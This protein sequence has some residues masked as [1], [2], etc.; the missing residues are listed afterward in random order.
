MIVCSRDGVKLPFLT[1]THSE[2]GEFG[3]PKWK[4]LHNAIADLDS[5]VSHFIKFSSKRERFYRLLSAGQNWKDLPKNL[6]KEALGNSY[7]AG[8]GKTGFY[9]RLSWNKPSP[10]L[11][12]H[13]AMPATDLAHPQELRPLSVEE[14]KKIQEFPDDWKI[15]GNILDQYKQIGNAVPLSLGYAIGRQIIL[16]LRGE[17]SNSFSG[18]SF[19]RYKDTDDQSWTANHQIKL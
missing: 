3:L 8:G 10:T 1:P 14:Y 16:A 18:F 2:K 6:Q 11:V 19:S 4:T 9:R 5:T 7:Y 15:A 13:P 12:T 17:I